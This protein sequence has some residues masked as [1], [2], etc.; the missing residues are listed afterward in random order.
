MAMNNYDS[1]LLKNQL[2]FPLYAV[3][4]EII[5]KY[6]PAL[7]R[8]DL[9]YTQY[10]TMMAMWEYEKL[11]VKELGEKLFLDS[12]TLTPV[13]KK[14][15]SKGYILRQRSPQ[16]ERSVIITITGEGMLLRERAL[17]VPRE[18]AGC[19]SLGSDEAMQLYMIL[20][21]ILGQVASEESPA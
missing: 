16:D 11:T 6:K 17:D 2:C 9:T 15:E 12:G 1:L 8:L 4:K 7:D 20:Y 5:K 18:M 19:V 13:L 10:I 21:K 14:L 3:S